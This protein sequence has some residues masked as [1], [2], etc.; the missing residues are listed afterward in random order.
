MCSW[1]AGRTSRRMSQDRRGLRTSGSPSGGRGEAR[2]SSYRGRAATL[3]A[4]Q[5]W[6]DVNMSRSTWY[7][8]Q[9]EARKGK[10]RKS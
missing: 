9:A 7:R 1:A 3:A 5:P 8:R 2:P 6:L 10:K 4:T